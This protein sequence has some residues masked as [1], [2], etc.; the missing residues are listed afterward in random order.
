MISTGLLF[1]R[2]NSRRIPGLTH[3]YFASQKN[4]SAGHLEVIDGREPDR[5][6]S[7]VRRINAVVVRR[8]LQVVREVGALVIDEIFDGD[9]EAF[10]R[11]DAHKSNGLRRLGRH[12][13]LMIS[14]TSLH[15]YV[16]V[17]RQ[18]QDM[19]VQLAEA[20]PF[21]AHRA[22]LPI[23]E[24]A[25][26]ERLARMAVAQ[27][28]SGRQVEREVRARLP[29][30]GRTGRPRRTELTRMVEALD[31]LL[32]EEALTSIA[33]EDPSTASDHELRRALAALH[34]SRTEVERL[35]RYV[36]RLSAD[37]L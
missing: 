8:G 10:A 27:G 29:R 5:M 9:Y 23:A 21:R 35:L 1:T 25:E 37:R 7:L 24:P 30:S 18:L 31:R 17:A 11:K 3:R 19:D 12:P 16:R 20:L 28:R 32:S 13:D 15:Y 4:M 22:L 14:A 36:A 33:G 34:R 2:V 26:K 6:D